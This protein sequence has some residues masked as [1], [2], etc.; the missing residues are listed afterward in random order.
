MTALRVLLVEDD[1]LYARVLRMTLQGSKVD[2]RIEVVET[3]E[4]ALAAI[5]AR[6]LDVVLLDLGL[7]DAEGL[8][9]VTA[10]R[11]LAP[12]L[13]IVVLSGHDDVDTALETMR[14]GAQEYLV[15]GQAEEVLV[16]RAIR[17]AIER[18]RMQELEQLLIGIVSH[19]LRNPMQTME[20][21]CDLLRDSNELSDADRSIIERLSRAVS[22]ST[23]LV[24]ALLDLARTRLG[25][26]LPIDREDAVLAEIVEGVVD[27]LRTM[28]PERTLRVSVSGDT[29]GRWDR[30]RLEQLVANLVGNA[31]QHS[32]ED[33]VV[34]VVCRRE[35]DRVVLTVWNDGP[36][37]GPE[38]LPR[39]FEPFRSSG[40]GERIG[41]G[42]Y[43]V[44]QIVRAHGGEIEVTSSR[45]EGTTF[46]VS[47]PSGR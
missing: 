1:P 36:P 4:A 25:Q 47:L 31:L 12:R 21:S 45:E 19:D 9:T 2:Y 39:I 14:L 22:R 6:P 20:M 42:L 23:E 34:E 44:D 37:I 46:R 33:C 5:P 3:L 15:K 35:G 16:P 13:P 41:L 43:I 26:R 17:Y 30:G 28:H 29:A 7:P 11:E 18:R 10:V 27:A 24:H 40:A 32:A 8:E 38:L